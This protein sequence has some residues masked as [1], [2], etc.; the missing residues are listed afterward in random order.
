MPT[1]APE[2]LLKD[3]STLS[4]TKHRHIH[5]RGKPSKARDLREV[6]HTSGNKII[7]RTISDCIKSLSLLEYR[8]PFHVPV[9]AKSVC[10]CIA[11]SL[12]I[13]HRVNSNSGRKS[14][15]LA[16]NLASL[17][18]QNC[19]QVSPFF[20]PTCLL[21]PSHLCRLPVEG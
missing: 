11:A 20:P 2:I 1:L 3:S 16:P 4:Q 6:T 17:Q 12:H 21:F 8:I 15:R 14:W 9:S 19:H 10:V 18:W 5:D 13:P 7:N